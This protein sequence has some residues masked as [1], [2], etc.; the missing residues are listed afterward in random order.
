MKL[1]EAGRT[2]GMPRGGRP[3]A[4]ALSARD[5]DAA[6]ACFAVDGCLLTPDATA[7]HG[8]DGIRAVL[9]QLIDPGIEVA[10][11][12]STA[13]SGAGVVLVSERWSVRSRGPEG[14]GMRQTLEPLLVLRCIESRWK[15]V[16]AEPWRSRGI[17]LPPAARG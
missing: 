2:E 11:E 6:T 14:R 16:I 5:L 1:Q 10:V 15:L 12:L 9:A 7:I 8:R 3:L 17:P 4:A 13:I